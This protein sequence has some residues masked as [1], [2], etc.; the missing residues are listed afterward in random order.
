MPGGLFCWR[1]KRMT[2]LALRARG[3][4]RR[5]ALYDDTPVASAVFM[6]K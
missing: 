4:F 2:A 6:G 3:G 5:I 1:E